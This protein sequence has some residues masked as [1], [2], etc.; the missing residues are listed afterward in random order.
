MVLLCT[1]DL[2]YNCI[3]H[4][5]QHKCE[6]QFVTILHSLSVVHFVLNLMAFLFY[7]SIFLD[8]GS[9]FIGPHVTQL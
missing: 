7:I 8:V 2:Y 5:D 4:I 1:I 6:S 3:Q 9:T